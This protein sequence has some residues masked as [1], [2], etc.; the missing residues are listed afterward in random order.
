MN[1]EKDIDMVT[2]DYLSDISRPKKDPFNLPSTSIGMKKREHIYIFW[3]ESVG[4]FV[5]T[6]ATYASK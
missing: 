3:F 6:F 5:L 2:K 1:E 4:T